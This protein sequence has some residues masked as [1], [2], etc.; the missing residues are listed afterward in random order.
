MDLTLKQKAVS[1]AAMLLTDS[2]VEKIGKEP[3]DKEDRN[4]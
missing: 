1:G 3:R 2:R 4:G